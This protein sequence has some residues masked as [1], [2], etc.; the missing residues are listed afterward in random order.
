MAV[1]AMLSYRL[2]TTV[3]AVCGGAIVYFLVRLYKARSDFYHSKVKTGQPMPP[4]NP[5]FG[6][7]LV[8][9]KAFKM[10]N[11]PPDTQMPDVLAGL[12]KEF[13]HE[14]DSLFYLD[15]WPFMRPMMM[16]SSPSLAIQACQSAEFAV[17]RPDDL[18]RTMHAVTG[19][20]SIFATNGPA[21][22]EA[23]NILQ[24]GLNSS[25]ILNQTSHIVDEAE[26]FVKILEERASRN[27]I[28]QLDHLTVKY[29][30]DI[31]GHLTL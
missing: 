28:F 4:W 10:Y 6:H 22:K 24:S 2:F 12:S 29:L 25:S 1:F 26:V 27:E 13:Q 20:P 21:W 3:V 23:R 9:D 11:L 8:L 18:L 30:L 31:S 5:L 7:L 15:I 17:D 19:G 16:V 14:S